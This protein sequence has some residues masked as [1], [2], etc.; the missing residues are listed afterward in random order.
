V[1]YSL[2]PEVLDG[3]RT[4]PLEIAAVANTEGRT[5]GVE[6]LASGT[7]VSTGPGGGDLGLP[8]RFELRANYPNPFNPATQIRFALPEASEVR[9]E[10]FDA[11]GR[12]VAVLADGMRS[13]GVH[14][15]SFQA[16]SL[17]SGVYIARLTA[18]GFV[19]S[20]AM[21]LLK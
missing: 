7:G 19:Q 15:V 13:A 6:L 4:L 18:P 10:V 3:A 20:R 9:L 17:S 1:P 16:G 11:P 2:D 12:R 5:L 8:E 21:V 14:T